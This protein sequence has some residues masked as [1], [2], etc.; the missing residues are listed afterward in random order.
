MA[1]YKVK[2]GD[3]VKVGSWDLPVVV[4]RIYHVDEQD[5]EVFDFESNR[6]VLLL[7]WEGHGQS[8]VFMHDEGKSWKQY[9][10]IN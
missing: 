6:T 3:K 1:N 7:D 2:V 5:N 4:K 10:N 8:K 9:F